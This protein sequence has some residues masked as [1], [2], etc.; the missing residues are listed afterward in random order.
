MFKKK[1]RVAAEPTNLIFDM[2]SWI[3]SAFSFVEMKKPNILK[4]FCLI[5]FL[6]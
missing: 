1:K 3:I 4:I 5:F 6:L 2:E